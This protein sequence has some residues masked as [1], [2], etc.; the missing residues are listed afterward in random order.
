MQVADFS[1]NVLFSGNLG[2]KLW[3]PESLEFDDEKTFL[4]TLTPAR[5]NPI[6]FSKKQIKFP[7]GHFHIREKK[8]QALHSFAGH[9][10]L[11]IEIMAW[12]LGAFPHNTQELKQFKKGVFN[13]LKEEQHHFKL[14]QD[15]LN[16]LGYEFGDFPINDFFWNQVEKMKTPSQYL[17]IMSLTFEAA[18]LDFASFYLEI[19]KSLG[20]DKIA[21]ALETVLRDEIKHVHFGAQ[22][23]KRWRQDKSLWNYYV[24]NLPW[25]LTP[26]R[27]KGQVFKPELRAQAGL[28]DEFIQELQ[29]FDDQFN[30]TKR[31]EW[32]DR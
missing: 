10:L 8:A 27:S 31:K 4:Q 29:R 14:Y 17:A 5:E 15:C 7:K 19:F 30:V 6:K 25:P 28:N 12:A 16:E 11:A 13:A 26:M 3:A 23:L 21:K 20:D 22:Y 2:H 24:E 9:E 1:R 32:K 18:N